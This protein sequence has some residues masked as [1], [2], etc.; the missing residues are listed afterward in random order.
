[1]I[2]DE[3]FRVPIQFEQCGVICGDGVELMGLASVRSV[4]GEA[5]AV[6]LYIPG[7][8]DNAYQQRKNHLLALKATEAGFGCVMANSRGQDYYGY[9][10]KYPDPANPSEYS[11]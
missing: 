3:R 11:W 9:Q 7:Q 1:M 2:Y 10:R 8:F 4:S 6:L 5:D